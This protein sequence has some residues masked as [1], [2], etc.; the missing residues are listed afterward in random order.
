[1]RHTKQKDESMANGY[2]EGGIAPINQISFGNDAQLGLNNTYDTSR[3]SRSEQPSK[4]TPNNDYWSQSNIT[5][6]SFQL[7]GRNGIANPFANNPD[8]IGFI[9]KTT[10]EKMNEF[11]EKVEIPIRRNEIAWA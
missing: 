9:G 8:A 2:N 5:K 7:V 3:V 10:V 6:S 4:Y 11:G 1:M